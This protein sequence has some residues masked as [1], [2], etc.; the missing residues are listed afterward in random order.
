MEIY[1]EL[2]EEELEGERRKK[3]LAEMVGIGEITPKEMEAMLD[4][5]D[6]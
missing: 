4:E 5:E 6:G 3:I 2:E 1:E